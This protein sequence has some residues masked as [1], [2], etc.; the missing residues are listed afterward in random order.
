[1]K[2]FD[3]EVRV[4]YSDTDAGGVVYHSKYLDFCE[5]ARTEFLRS[6]GIIQTKMLEET[7]VGFV[8]SKCNISYKKPAKLDDLLLILTIIEDISPVSIKMKQQVFLKGNK[9]LLTEVEIVIVCVNRDF[10][11]IKI[12]SEIKNILM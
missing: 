2:S 8:V 5:K 10:K 4:Y 9:L 7:G 1:M 12:P 3:F 11:L 6:C